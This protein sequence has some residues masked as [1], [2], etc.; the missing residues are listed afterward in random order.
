[1][2]FAL[3]AFLASAQAVQLNGIYDTVEAGWEG[4]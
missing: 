4:Q 2:K 1:M 3:I